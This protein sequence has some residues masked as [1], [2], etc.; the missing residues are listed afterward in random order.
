M[1]EPGNVRQPIISAILFVVELEL[2]PKVAE[3]NRARSLGHKLDCLTDG[4]MMT[5]HAMV[6]QLWAPGP[7]LLLNALQNVFVKLSLKERTDNSHA[8]TAAC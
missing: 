6:G 7:Y 1:L 5:A 4:K 3:G 2:A 8:D